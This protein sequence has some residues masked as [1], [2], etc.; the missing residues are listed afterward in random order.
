MGGGH[1][2]GPRPLPAV[3]DAVEVVVQQYTSSLSSTEIYPIT[4]STNPLRTATDDELVG[5][6]TLATRRGNQRSSESG[7]V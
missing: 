1:G 5:I 4:D 6:L 2:H 7:R 3:D